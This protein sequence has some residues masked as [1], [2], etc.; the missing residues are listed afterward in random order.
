MGLEDEEAYGHGSVGLLQLG[1]VAGEELRQGDEVAQRLAHLLAV[2]GDHV[3][4]HPVV[5][6][7]GA[8]RRLVLGYLAFM[9]GKNQVHS[10]TVDVE[11]AAEVFL[12]HH[13]AFEMPAGETVAP[14]RRPAHDM[15][16]FGLLPEGEVV[17][18]ALVGLAVKA[19]RALER[20]FEIA[21]GKHS[22]MIVPIVFLHIEIHAS[23]AHVG[24]SRIENLLHRLY[25]LYDVA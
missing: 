21:S 25:L 6:A 22:V 23:V 11:F 10:A 4:V 15:F 9:V 20:V 19:A 17:G 14:G 5:D 8:A 1:M 18:V 7:A 24:V 13:R 3:V 12:P 16:G 2:D